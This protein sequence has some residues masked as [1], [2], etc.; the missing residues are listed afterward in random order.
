M[1]FLLLLLLGLLPSAALALAP[2][3][4]PFEYDWSRFPAAWFAGND[5]V[6][7]DPAQIAE[8][9]RY[10][11]AILGWQDLITATNWTA[12]VYAQLDQAAIIKAHYPD[13]PVFVYTG[14]GNADGYNEA[15][16]K[17]MAPAFENCTVNQPCNHG[18][19]YADYF[20]QS[21]STP[22]YSMSGCEQMGLGYSNPPTP[23]CVNF[24]WNTA[25]EAAIDFFVDEVVGPLA[26]APQI[27]GVF[28]DCFNYAYDI[29]AVRPWGRPVVNV[30]GCGA[31]GGAGCEALVAG[32]LKMARKTAEKLNSG[33][34]V[35]MFANPAS[36]ENTGNQPIWLDEARLLST[37]DAEPRTTWSTY[38][39]F[40]RAELIKENGQLAN[41]LREGIG[42]GNRSTRSSSTTRT[43]TTATTTTTTGTVAAGVHV[44]YQQANASCHA[45]ATTG[46]TCPLEDVSPHLA[47]FMLVREEHWYYFGSTGWLDRNFEWSALYDKYSA[48]GSPLA[49]AAETAANLFTRR[50]DHCTVTLDCTD[51]A[52]CPKQKEGPCCK[53]SVATAME[54]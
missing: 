21:T 28:F 53:A 46:V 8:I 51:P 19:P 54:A 52:P 43:T 27:D 5:T 31:S 29:P 36:F 30:P 23:K 24:F 25:N 48:C 7:E 26:A 3:E 10:E 12:S 2:G 47:A 40:M 34:K 39:E 13:L 18:A 9:G 42:G 35:P 22:E 14:F 45:N 49:K 6:W 17:L 4:W 33:G 11:L 44:Y 15:T 1:R 37:L 32:A 41:M 20:L 38:Y 16:W 50:Y